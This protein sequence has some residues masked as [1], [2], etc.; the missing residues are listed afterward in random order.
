VVAVS[1][2]GFPFISSDLFD[3]LKS[4]ASLEA[5]YVYV[6]DESGR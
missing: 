1:F 4:A 6:E 3:S 2:A 5:V